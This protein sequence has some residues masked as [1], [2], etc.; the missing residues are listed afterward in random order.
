MLAAKYG[1]RT[2]D[3]VKRSGANGNG[4]ASKSKTR[5]DL[6]R[7]AL[8]VT[9]ASAAR[10]TGA[11]MLDEYLRSDGLL[12]VDLGASLTPTQRKAVLEVSICV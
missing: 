7:L 3:S 12:K 9:A 4:M 11:I 5:M 10:S 2:L 6:R 1:G 8:L